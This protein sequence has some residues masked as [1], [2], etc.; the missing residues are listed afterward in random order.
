MGNRNDGGAE[1]IQPSSKQLRPDHSA[2]RSAAERHGSLQSNGTVLDELEFVLGARD[3]PHKAPGQI[4]LSVVLDDL[5]E[6]GAPVI[7]SATTTGDSRVELRAI[8]KD[9]SGRELP[10]VFLKPTETGQRA[11]ING[12]SPGGYEITVGGVGTAATRVAPITCPILVWAPE[13]TDG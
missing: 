2:I 9:E 1:P 11:D 12:L 3:T 4:E 10:P 5:V 13:T 8:V 6:A 7:L